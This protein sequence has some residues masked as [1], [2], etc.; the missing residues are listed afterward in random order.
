MLCQG[1]LVEWVSND[2]NRTDYPQYIGTVATVTEVL[3]LTHH[4]SWEGERI[5]YC[6]SIEAHDG[7]CERGL[8]PLRFKPYQQKEP[9]WYL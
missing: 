7:F 6:V 3:H 9:S 2:I 4:A 5:T 8:Y 1:E